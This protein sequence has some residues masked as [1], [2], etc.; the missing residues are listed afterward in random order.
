[1]STDDLRSHDGA[2]HGEGLEIIESVLGQGNT[3]V[4]GLYLYT[5]VALLLAEVRRNPRLRKIRPQ[6]IGTPSILL[7][8]PRISQAEL[9]RYLGCSRAAAGLQVAACVREGWVSRRRSTHDRRIF[10]LELTASGR[11][12]LAEVASIV[13]QHERAT[14]AALSEREQATLRQLLRQFIV[15]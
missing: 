8:R 9:A 15:G 14:F 12:M 6:L 4:L 11:R 13:V 7:V 1:M 2:R 3:P 5:A 10:Q